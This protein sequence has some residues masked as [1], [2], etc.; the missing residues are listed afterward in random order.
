MPKACT[1]DC[2]GPEKWQQETEDLAA[3]DYTVK[4]GNKVV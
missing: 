3:G 1:A 2:G 4:I